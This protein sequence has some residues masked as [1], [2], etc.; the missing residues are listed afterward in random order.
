MNALL[1]Q[2]EQPQRSLELKLA[3]LLFVVYYTVGVNAFSQITSAVYDFLLRINVSE[4]DAK[5]FKWVTAPIPTDDPLVYIALRFLVFAIW[6]L[7]V[8]VFL[9]SIFDIW[10]RGTDMSIAVASIAFTLFTFQAVNWLGSWLLLAS[11]PLIVF[12]AAIVIMI[13]LIIVALRGKEEYF[14]EEE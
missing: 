6:L 7:L 4:G 9:H 5:V 11:I 12:S 10:G 13:A 8:H 2:F 14:K 3:G 1:R